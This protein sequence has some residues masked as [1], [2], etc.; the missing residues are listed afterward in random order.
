MIL[1][2]L[3]CDLDLRFIFFLLLGLRFARSEIVELLIPYLLVLWPGLV[4]ADL[5]LHLKCNYE[6][7]LYTSNYLS[8]Q[9]HFDQQLKREVHGFV[10]NKVNAHYPLLIQIII[11]TDKSQHF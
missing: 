10:T 2:D 5:G 9:N 11:Q 8:N 6:Y 3:Y 1:E 4:Q 7:Y